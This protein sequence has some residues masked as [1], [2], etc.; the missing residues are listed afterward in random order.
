MVRKRTLI[1]TGASIA[2]MV[3]VAQTWLVFRHLVERG[4]VH[5]PAV[6]GADLNRVVLSV[7]WYPLDVLVGERIVVFGPFWLPGILGF[8]I[9]IALCLLGFLVPWYF[10]AGR[11][12]NEFM[13][14]R[15]QVF[16]AL[17]FLA[18]YLKTG[19]SLSEALIS[20]AKT[21][22][23]PLGPYLHNYALLINVNVLSSSRAFDIVFKDL[24]RDV[25]VLL[26]ILNIAV[27][28]GRPA[29]A[30][31]AAASHASNIK[32]FDD[33]RSSRLASSIAIVYTGV[34]AYVVTSIIVSALMEVFPRTGIGVPQALAVATPVEHVLVIYFI[35]SIFIALVSSIMVAR[36]V[37]GITIAFVRYFFWLLLAIIICFMFVKP[38]V[39]AL[40]SQI[41]VFPTPPLPGT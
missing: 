39:L 7:T 1:V 12:L 21:L 35:S 10:E 29:D 41:G 22:K 34:I 23:K 37:K 27:R 40:S 36:V 17:Q 6:A 9:F 25:R 2:S 32:R 8:Y 24:P 19:V 31:K 13:A 11:R 15:R 30:L 4:I 33:L 5:I 18:S 26:G 20:L 16:E 38:I 28:G 14:L 3:L